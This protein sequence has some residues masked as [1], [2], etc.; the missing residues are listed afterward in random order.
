MRA[1]GTIKIEFAAGMN[2]LDCFVE[3]ERIASELDVYCEFNFNGI[4]CI[5]YS[6]ASIDECVKKYEYS[7]SG[8]GAQSNT[9]QEAKVD[10]AADDTWYEILD[11]VHDAT[12]NFLYYDREEDE[13]LSV[14]QLE[15]YISEDKE[16]RIN[17]ITEEFK[18]NL[19]EML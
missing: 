6:G 13:D 4:M 15:K 7:L 10:R 16:T 9:E 2:V 5:I 17:E 19:I 3:A 12:I 14:E 18:R 8:F 11:A 1:R